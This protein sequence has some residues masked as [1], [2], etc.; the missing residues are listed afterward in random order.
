[1]IHTHT[2]IANGM[3]DVRRHLLHTTFPTICASR[4]IVVTVIDVCVA[5]LSGL[6]GVLA[7]R[8][9]HRKA[10]EVDLLAQPP[11]RTLVEGKVW[12]MRRN[13]EYFMVLCFMHWN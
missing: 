6:H 4:R 11:L 1:M 3:R 12:S 9:V 7:C 2:K 10:E 5:R 8:R 13:Y